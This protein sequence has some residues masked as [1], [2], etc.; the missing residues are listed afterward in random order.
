MDKTPNPN[1]SI[2]QL[3]WDVRDCRLVTGNAP[4]KC[5][6]G[7]RREKTTH[8][9]TTS[10]VRLLMFTLISRC[11]P[12]AKYSTFVSEGQLYKKTGL[13]VATIKRAAQ[14]LKELGLIETEPQWN[15]SNIWYINSRHLHEEAERQRADARAIKSAR[16]EINSPFEQPVITV[17]ATTTS[18]TERTASEKRVAKFTKPE[19]EVSG[20][21]VRRILDLLKSHLG[22]HPTYA[23]KDAGA[24]MRSCVNGCIDLAGNPE[25]C[26]DVFS[27]AFADEE[28]REKV[29][30]QAKNLG[31]IHIKVL[32]DLARGMPR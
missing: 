3:I 30:S 29:L 21:A 18:E 14:R 28:R 6:K 15:S 5:A 17:K 19:T 13:S 31:G 32:L 23:H 4:K 12:S 9:V 16:R 8:Y 1:L 25:A 20:E 10:A 11:D 2:A 22:T 7:S 27:W 26:F 24:M